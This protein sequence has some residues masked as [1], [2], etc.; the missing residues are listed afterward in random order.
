MTTKETQAHPVPKE[1]LNPAGVFAHPM[2]VVH[3]KDLTTEEKQPFSGPGRPM[4]V[5][6]SAQTTRECRLVRDRGSTMWRSHWP[7]SMPRQGEKEFPA[8]AIGFEVLRCFQCSA[9]KS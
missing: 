2:Q 5:L 4:R 9:G 7:L 6:C 8:L 1:E 3:A